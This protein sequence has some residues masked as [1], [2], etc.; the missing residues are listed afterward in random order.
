MLQRKTSW[1][2]ADLARF[3]EVYSSE[4]TIEAAVAEA[5]ARCGVVW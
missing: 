2:P 5:K 1:G 4:H 3:T